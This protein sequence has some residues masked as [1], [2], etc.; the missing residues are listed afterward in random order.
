M[1]TRPSPTAPPKGP[2]KRRPTKPKPQRRRRRRRPAQLGLSARGR[3][4]GYRHGAGRKRIPRDQRGY[5]PHLPRPRVTK[6]TPVHVTLRCVEGLPSLRRR[7]T[8]RLIEIIFASENRKGFRLAHYSIQS[9]HLHLIAEGN[10]TTSLSRGIQ[11]IASRI[12]RQ[13]NQHL[14]RR[15]RLFRERFDGKVLATPKQVRN[16]LRYVLLNRQKHELEHRGRYLRRLDPFSSASHF[17]GW[18][19]HPNAPKR[20]PPPSP[21][22]TPPKSWLLT[23]GWRRHGLLAPTWR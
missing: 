18:A 8:Q 17:D 6:A 19:P 22:I 3:R 13:L 16:A 10:D 15:G 7:R 9:N 5:V 12:A 14:G 21:A 23:T 11:R 20:A 4:G 1:P 2:P